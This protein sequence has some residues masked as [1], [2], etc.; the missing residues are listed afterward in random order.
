METSDRG[1]AKLKS[2]TLTGNKL[3]GVFVIE[4]GSSIRLDDCDI[5]GSTAGVQA[6]NGGSITIENSRIGKNTNGFSGLNPGTVEIRKSKIRQNLLHGIALESASAG[7][8]SVVQIDG[9][10]INNNGQA[11]IFVGGSALKPDVTGNDIGPNGHDLCVQDGAGGRYEKNVLRT[12]DEPIL[13]DDPAV[14]QRENQ[15]APGTQ[16]SPD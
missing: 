11:G 1:S 5:T 10:T 13:A 3:A 6:E 12:K 14:L 7:A 2:T 16:P 4:T 9:N 8:A 15:M